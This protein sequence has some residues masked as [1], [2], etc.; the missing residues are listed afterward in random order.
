MTGIP[1]DELKRYLPALQAVT[2]KQAQIAAA[3][4]IDADQPIIVVVG[5]APALKPQLEKV[6]KV[7]VVDNDGN[8]TKE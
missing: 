1:I 6:G 5:D 2:P 7:V 8:I 4:Y 3:K